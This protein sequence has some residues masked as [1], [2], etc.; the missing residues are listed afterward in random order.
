MWFLIES[1]DMFGIGKDEKQRFLLNEESVKFK[2]NLDYLNAVNIT[3]LGTEVHP[4]TDG[5]E[6]EL[7][8]NLLKKEPL[9]FVY[10]DSRQGHFEHTHKDTG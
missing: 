9:H 2:R 1:K 8:T 10:D 6:E 4:A 7:D 3:A 5:T